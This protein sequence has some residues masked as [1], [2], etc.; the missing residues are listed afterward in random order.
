MREQIIQAPSRTRAGRVSHQLAILIPGFSQML[1]IDNGWNQ[2]ASVSNPRPLA[3]ISKCGQLGHGHQSLKVPNVEFDFDVCVDSI[4][5][6]APTLKTKHRIYFTKRDITQPNPKWPSYSFLTLGFW[7]KRTEVKTHMENLT[8][9]AYL[10]Q[11][12]SK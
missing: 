6:R 12:F 9:A 5:L 4:Q 11:Q 2:P 8:Y 10:A 3:S 7:H 1:N